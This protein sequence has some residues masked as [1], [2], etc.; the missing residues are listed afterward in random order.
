MSVAEV[1]FNVTPVANCLTVK[2]QVALLLLPSA[3]VTVMVADPGAL[4]VTRPVVL[5]VATVVLLDFQVTALLEVLLGL[6]VAVSCKV[7]P[8]FSVAEVLL[9]DTPVASCFT[10]TVQVAVLFVPS[11]VLAVIVAVP[12]PLAVTRP[13]LLTE[14]TL[15]LLVVQDTLLSVALLGATVAE[16]CNV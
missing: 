11:Q 16:R 2:A 14:A 7:W 9:S 6:T 12:G 15:E 13:L 5:T 8:V 4:A 3:V 10:V 1:L